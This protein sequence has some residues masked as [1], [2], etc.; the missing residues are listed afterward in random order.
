MFAY[1]KFKIES[2]FYAEFINELIEREI[3]IK[4]IRYNDLTVT[5]VCKAR[6][7]KEV[8]KLGK[9]FGCRV[10]KIKKYGFYFEIKPI[11]NRK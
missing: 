9:K 2:G 3:Y 10:R 1:V 11:L 6:D 8:A 7:Y 4:N 5:A